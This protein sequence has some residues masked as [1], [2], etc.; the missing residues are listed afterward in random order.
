MVHTSF[1]AKVALSFD[2]PS[3]VARWQRVGRAI[4]RDREAQPEESG[5]RP[6]RDPEGTGVKTGG[7]ELSPAGPG[8][9]RPGASGRGGGPAVLQLFLSPSSR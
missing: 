7:R 5:C 4:W 9:S 2:Q 8:L 6:G 1:S 3:K